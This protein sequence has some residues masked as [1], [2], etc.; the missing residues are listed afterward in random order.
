MDNEI[1]MLIQF[2]SQKSYLTLKEIEIG[3]NITRRQATYRIEKLNALLKSARVPLIT[4]GSSSAREIVIQEETRR[5]MI[6]M[7]E[8]VK[9]GNQ[10]YLN[11][12]ERLIYM[13][14]MLFINPDYLSLNDFID[15][16][17]VSRSTV[18]LDFKD[19]SKML[20]EGNVEI[21]NNRVRGY[22][23]VGSEMEIRRIMMKYVIFSLAEKKSKRVFDRFIDDYQLDVFDYSKLVITELAQAYHIRFVEDR[24][25]EFI[26]IFIFLKARMLNGKGASE[27]M[28][29]LLDIDVISTM[30]EYGFTR[31]LLKNYKNTDRISMLDRYYITSWIL[32]ISFGDINEDTKDCILISDI[33]GKIMTRFESL[34]GA[35]YHNK[36]EIFIQLYS[37]FR[38]AYYRLM[39]KLPIYNPLCEKVKIEYGGLYQL[40][41][42]TMKPLN[43]IFGDTIPDDEIAYLTMHF[44]TIYSGKK[45]CEIASQKVALV[46]CSNG[47]GS[48]SILYNELTDMFPELHFLPPM[49]SSRVR[50]LNEHV[51]IVFATNYIANLDHIGVPI[52]RVSPVMNISERY[53]VVREVYMQLGN[54]FMKQPNVD[55][56]M[57]IISQ[58]AEIREEQALYNELIAYFAKVDAPQNNHPILHLTDM[59]SA[60]IIRVNIEAKD[61][62]QA[63]RLSYE[64]MVEQ[65]MITQNYV[66]ETIRSVRM[67]GPY[68]VITPHTALSHTKRE[69]GALCCALGISVLKEAV[70][71]GSEGNDPVKYIF[72]L[73]ANDNETHLGAM[74][75]LVELLNCPDFFALLDTAQSAA[76]IIAYLTMYEH[77]KQQLQE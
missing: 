76:D 65:G 43:V 41:E 27:D 58:Y 63:I 59:V 61:W 2:L 57:N 17:G 77:K 38:P 24:L 55:V 47:I 67:V 8:E 74:A 7:A 5:A 31:D 39:F 9:K 62:E 36:Q 30:K 20:E 37:H 68:I 18:L 10:Y 69:A 16:L 15:S 50:E 71:F 6:R 32:G 49:E 45:E 44:A 23:F 13:Y 35:R 33:V 60:E 4:I 46:V 42:E 51:D 25:V 21:R 72:S 19:L 56:V 75:E 64:P 1:I 3:I 12:K 29:H 40:V 54:T 11:K 34:S 52:I 14:L 70:E 26:Y 73:S 28:V 22:F 48:S 66:E 53:Q